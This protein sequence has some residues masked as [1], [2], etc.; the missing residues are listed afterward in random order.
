M[1]AL[2]IDIGGTGIK[3]AVVDTKHGVLKTDRLRLLT[4]HPAEPDA[5]AEVVQ[6][7][8]RHFDWT[9]PVGCTFPGVTKGGLVHTAANLDPSWIGLDG[10]NLFATA[11]GCPVT[12][13][14]DADAAGLAEAA[15]GAARGNEGVVLMVTLGTG[16]GTALV[17]DGRLVPN[18]ELGH[19]PLN[20]GDAEKYAAEIVRERDNLGYDEWGRRVG[21]YLRLIE[22]LVWP[23]LFVLGGG[24][25]KKADKFE[26]FLDCRTPVV[27]ARLLNQAG[28]VG[29]ALQ[30]VRAGEKSKPKH[31]DKK[32]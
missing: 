9:G 17:C 27:P 30:A 24:I 2:G 10:A 16:I 25:S 31:K 32:K 12:V 1:K 28:I 19:V 20:G 23:D 3:G 13:L 8:A 7:L 5:V 22:D 21:E 6:T 26:E 29:A 11:T 15:F 18:T 4:P 14:N